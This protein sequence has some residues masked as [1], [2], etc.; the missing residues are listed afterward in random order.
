ML[1]E[2]AELI[3]LQKDERFQYGTIDF[4]NPKGDPFRILPHLNDQR[5]KVMELILELKQHG[6]IRVESVSLGDKKFAVYAVG[7]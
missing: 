3:C 5:E 6:R 4:L 1:V 2:L 7:T